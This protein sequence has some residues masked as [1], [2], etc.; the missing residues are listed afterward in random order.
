MIHDT[1]T[2][3]SGCSPLYKFI[4]FA[5]ELEELV[6]KGTPNSSFF[7]F[8][9]DDATDQFRKY[10]ESV[11]WPAVAMVTIKPK[12]FIR[13]V[14]AIGPNGDYWELEPASTQ[15]TVGKITDFYGNLR[16]LSVIDETIFACGMGRVVLQREGKGKWKPIGPKPTQDDADVIGFEDIDGYS[17]TEIYAVGWGGEI[18]WFDNG[19]WRRM[20]SPTSVNLTALC[21]AADESVYIVGHDGIMLRGRYDS[22]SVI[23]TDRKENLR[24]VAYYNGTIYVT[25]DFRIL[26]LVDNKLV[27]D[28]DFADPDDLPVTCLH[29][30]T[31]AD[32]LISLG[33]KDVFRRQQD[34][35]KRLV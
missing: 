21:C 1:S 7:R 2:F 16:T 11:G 25:T 28:T 17:R 9:E 8:Y 10:D 20:D 13:E 3:I 32:G 26:K 30:L 24:D 22:W 15:E 34:P 14:V 29:L 35:W 12:G 31:V 4:F 5:K 23:D 19:I 18:W 27:N 33:T 6:E